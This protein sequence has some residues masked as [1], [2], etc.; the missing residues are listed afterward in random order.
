[1]TKSSSTSAFGGYKMAPNGNEASQDAAQ[2]SN[3]QL[4][5]GS[6]AQKL[7]QQALPQR[8]SVFGANADAG[9]A[10]PGGSTFGGGYKMQ[11]IPT[12]A[13]VK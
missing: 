3:M 6:P 4:T 8:S 2:P 12:E 9:P 7:S 1:M 11:A 10:Q 5:K 13:E